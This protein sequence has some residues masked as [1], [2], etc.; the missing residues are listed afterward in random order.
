MTMAPTIGPNTV[1]KPADQRHQHD[2][3]G[4]GPVDVGERGELEDDRL[5]RAGKAGE[6]RREHEDHQ[7][8]LVGA[9]AERDGAG[10][11]VADRLADLAEGR[12]DDA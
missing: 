11:V 8:V 2:L 10:L 5:G 4:H 3:A 6:R 9:V 1:P 12:V 7:L